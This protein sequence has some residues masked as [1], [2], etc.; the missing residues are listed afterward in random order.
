[1]QRY[2]IL[3]VLF[4]SVLFFNACKNNRY[5]VDVS[6]IAAEANVYRLDS[7]VI[8]MDS[9]NY[10]NDFWSIYQKYPEAFS[11]IYEQMVRFPFRENDSLTA[12]RAKPLMCN[13][14]A[15]KLYKDVWNKYADIAWLK[16]DLS[17]AYKH[18]RYYYPND[19]L[20]DVYTMVSY[21]FFGAG[22]LDRKIYI[23]LDM[24]L[25]EDYEFYRSVQLPKYVIKNCK[26][27]Y[28]VSESMKAYF[29]EK[30]PI[31][32]YSGSNL[33]SQMIYEGKRLFFTDIMLPNVHDSIKIRYSAEELKWCKKYEGEI[34]NT[35]VKNKDLFTNDEFVIG[36]LLDD[37]PFTNAKG[38]PQDSPPRLGAWLGWQIVKAYANKLPIEQLITLFSELNEKEF[39]TKSEYKP[40]M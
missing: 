20:Y 18:I 37:G 35:L 31:E 33:L 34:W 21:Y 9:N 15:T 29:G 3:L 5:H 24:F 28:I 19:T 14:Y 32:D 25:G 1:M 11:Q 26:Q 36:K 8:H 12:Q 16:D 4:F 27:D 30:Y 10:E 22:A 17:D 39:L 13:P 23:S 2:L 38:I 40:K 7:M 6:D